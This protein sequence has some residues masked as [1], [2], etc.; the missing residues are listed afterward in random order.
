MTEKRDFSTEAALWDENPMKVKITSEIGDSIIA[1]VELTDKTDVLDFGCGTGILS[2]KLAPLVKSVTGTD[3]AKGM[4]DV[5]NAK[6]KRLGIGNTKAELIDV[7]KDGV[8]TG[9]Y[10]L[11]TS[12]MT[13]HHIKDTARLFK[14]FYNVLGDSGMLVVADLDLDNG[15]FHEDSSGVFHNGF[16]RKEF[17][18]SLAQTGFKDVRF[19]HA[20]EITKPSPDGEKNTFSVFL[21]TA[22]KRPVSVTDLGTDLFS[23]S[24]TRK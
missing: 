8:L 4:L 1:H 20:T 14:Q 23:D 5:F 6:T 10:N 11:V 15:K 7:E 21:A 9:T 19:F 12:S 18:D 24:P 16:D 13:L 22:R 17:A 2:F 3:S